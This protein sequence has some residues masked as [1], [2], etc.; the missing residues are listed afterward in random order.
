MGAVSRLHNIA[1]P[2]D[3]TALWGRELVWLWRVITEGGSE[4]SNIP[5]WNDAPERTWDDIDT[6]VAAYDRDRMLNL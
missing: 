5:R 2:A 6:V 4:G 3:T 1:G